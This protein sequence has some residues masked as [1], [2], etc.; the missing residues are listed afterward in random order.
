MSDP[1][2]WDVGLIRRYA[3]TEPRYTSYPAPE[4][5]NDGVVP[6]DLFAALHHSGQLRRP[7]SLYVHIPFCA[8][9]CHHCARVKTV[10]K[11]RNRAQ[12]YLQALLREIQLLSSHLNDGQRIERLHFGGGTPTFFGHDDLRRL[13]DTLRA[14]FNLHDDDIADYSI[15]IDPREV[16]WSTMGLLRELGFNQINIGVQDLDPGVQRAINRLQSTEQTQAVMDAARTLAFRRIG[17]D[18]TYG[19]PRQTPASF[20]ATLATVIALRPDHLRLY[21]YQHLPELFVSQ[22]KIL[23]DELPVSDAVLQIQIESFSRLEAAGYRFLGMGEFALSDTA[24][25]DAQENGELDRSLQGYVTAG[26]TDL[27]GLG[28]SAISQIGDFYCRNTSDIRQYQNRLEEGRPTLQYGL[29]CSADDRLRRAVIKQLVC[30]FELSFADIEKRFDIDFCVYFADSIGMLQQ[31]HRDGVLQLAPTGITILPAGKA[32][33]DRVCSVFDAYQNKS[34]TPM[35]VRA[36][37][38]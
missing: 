21:H 13:M 9:S 29:R 3:A 37:G 4:Q 20:A 24:L 19:L 7:L 17:I 6:T 34:S 14:Y 30:H 33:I 12:P 22:R 16:D 18:L 35:P 25:S 27:I 2:S 15:E 8:N 32:L 23:H 10:T 5:F 28:V 11:D 26:D 38:Y 1:V 31:M 36:T